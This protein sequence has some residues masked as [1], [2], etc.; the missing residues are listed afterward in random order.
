[1]EVWKKRLFIGYMR[2]G[3]YGDTGKAVKGNHDISTM[4]NNALI[5][6]EEENEKQKIEEK[7]RNKERASLS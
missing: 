2:E 5:G 6:E 7:E 3:K 1:M 4:A